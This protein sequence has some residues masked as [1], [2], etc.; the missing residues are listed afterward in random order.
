MLFTN[1]L[2]AQRLFYGD[3]VLSTATNRWVGKSTLFYDIIKNKVDSCYRVQHLTKNTVDEWGRD[4]TDSFVLDT[5]YIDAPVKNGKVEGRVI[6][7]RGDEKKIVQTI[8]YKEGK[9]EGKAFITNKSDTI[10]SCYY[11]NGLKEGLEIFNFSTLPSYTHTYFSK[12]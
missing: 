3:S 12:G 7:Y 9:A 2:T 10:F 6:F 1:K 4:I 8:E 5:I 11:K